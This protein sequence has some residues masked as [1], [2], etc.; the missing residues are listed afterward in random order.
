MAGGETRDKAFLGI[1]LLNSSFFM[2]FQLSC[3]TCCDISFFLHTQWSAHTEYAMMLCSHTLMHVYQ[4]TLC[5]LTFTIL[6]HNTC[7]HTH[8]HTYTQQ[9]THTHTHNTYA[10]LHMITLSNHDGT[11][12]CAYQ[13]PTYILFHLTAVVHVCARH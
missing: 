6:E 7:I 5:K 1:P 10:L 11:S 4:H 8:T 9:C 12:L 2:P 3:T 13:V